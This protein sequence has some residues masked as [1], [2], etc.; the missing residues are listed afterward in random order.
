MHI[1]FKSHPMTCPWKLLITLLQNVKR[2][3]VVA[4][5]GYHPHGIAIVTFAEYVQ[6]H[7]NG[8]L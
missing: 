8:K 2:V 5:F 3:E 4:F 6:D 1:S 7:V